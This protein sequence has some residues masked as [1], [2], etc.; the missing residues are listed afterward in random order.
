MDFNNTELTDHQNKVRKEIENELNQYK[1]LSNN[2]SS[3]SLLNDLVRQNMDLN[4]KLAE[5][6]M[7][8]KHLEEKILEVEQNMHLKN[9]Y[10]NSQIEEI[11]EL[12][13]KLEEYEKNKNKNID[14]YKNANSIIN[15]QKVI[16]SIMFLAISYLYMAC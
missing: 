14:L 5:F 12:K 1:N 11:N 3:T 7:S 10:A 9:N 4:T 16:I 13:G 6:K 15:L 8:N 2:F